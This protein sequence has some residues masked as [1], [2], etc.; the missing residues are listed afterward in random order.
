[1]AL[2]GHS[3][4]YA[5]NHEPDEEVPTP[6]GEAAFDDSESGEEWE[7]IDVGADNSAAAL[8]AA[9]AAAGNKELSITI[10]TAGKGKGK[11][12]V[13]SASSRARR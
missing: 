4:P 8:A 7:E 5:S 12:Y 2:A 6:A 11:K 1:M 13:R 9:T 10:A 3:S